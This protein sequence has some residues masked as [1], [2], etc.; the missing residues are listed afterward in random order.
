MLKAKFVKYDTFKGS[1]IVKLSI[2]AEKTR[3]NMTQV[4]NLDGCDVVVSLDNGQPLDTAAV[5]LT[6]VKESVEKLLAAFGGPEPEAP[7]G[8]TMPESKEG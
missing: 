7:A 1:N 8:E 3:E 4:V 6:Q 5:I 2:E